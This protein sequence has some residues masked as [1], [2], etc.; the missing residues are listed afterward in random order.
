MQR[1]IAS[2]LVELAYSARQNA[3]FVAAP[4]WEVETR[5]RLLKL[6]P[7][8]LG[9]QAEVPLTGKGFGVALDD[10]ANRL[11]LTQGFNGSIS[12]VDT[13]AGRLVKQIPLLQKINFAQAYK[14]RGF[15]EKRTEFLLKALERFKVVDDYPYKLR[16]MALDRANERL[17]A[18]GLGLGFDSVLFVVNTRTLE[19]EKVIEGFGYN[20][21]G[22]VLDEKNGRVFVSNMRGQVM[23]VDARTLQITRTLEVEA[24]QLLNLAYDPAHNRLFGV[25]QGID[26]DSWRNNHL[27]REYQHRSEGHRLF[28]L[29]ADTGKTIANLPSGQVP[30]GLRFDGER[31]RLYVTN[32]GGVRVDE[33]RGSVTVYDT[34]AY[35]L[36][37]TIDLPPHPN[38]LAL[39][40]QAN[41]LYVTVKNDGSSKKAG[42]LENVTRIE[43]R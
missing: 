13:A 5:S 18:P 41:V 39:D 14:E 9:I 21:V 23:V 10:A 32:R 24:D 11:Y 25:D 29:D 3:V 2:D 28:V 19:L 22:V 7:D 20:A 12:V 36:L 6:H 26:R 40:E 15:S 34:A 8:T 43:L 4:D 16:E 42:T 33:G 35:Q 27:E 30:I 37:Q 1:A 38:S 31:Q 17:F